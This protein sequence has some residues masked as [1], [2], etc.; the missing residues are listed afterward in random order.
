MLWEDIPH[1]LRHSIK[2]GKDFS[3]NWEKGERIKGIE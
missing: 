1:D 2:E 3:R